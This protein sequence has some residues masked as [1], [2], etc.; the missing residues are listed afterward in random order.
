MSP[1]TEQQLLEIKMPKMPEIKILT[2]ITEKEQGIVLWEQMLEDQLHED[3]I[4]WKL[5][6]G[7]LDVVEGLLYN[8]VNLDK[9]K[10]S[11]VI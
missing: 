11:G 7:L 8:E 4:N 1:L 9:L 6:T 5:I 3:T 10:K 2:H